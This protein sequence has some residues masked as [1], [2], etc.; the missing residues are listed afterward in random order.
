MA[1]VQAYTQ[2]Q[3]AQILGRNQGPEFFYAQ[4]VTALSSPILSKNLNL[5]RPLER[6]HL[7]LMM[8]V[9]I[10]GADYTT[11]SAEAP[12]NF[13][14]RLV[15]NGTHQTFGA[16]TPINMTGASI[17]TYLRNFRHYASSCYINGV[18]QPDPGVPYQ[19]VGTTFGNIGTYDLEIHYDLPVGPITAHAVKNSMIPYMWQ[20]ADWSD[21][22]QIQPFFGDPTSFG[23]PAGGTTVDLYAYGQNSGTPTMYFFNNYEILGPLANQIAG[24]V[25]I[26]S[27]QTV[28]GPVS[29]TSSIRYSLLFCKSKKR[30]TYLS[31]REHYLPVLPSA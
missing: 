15:V 9:V 3:L 18:R 20:P 29:S 14:Q 31:N 27:A 10:S 28:T 11:V 5:T 24:A 1:G 21:T 16:L 26:R 6:F 7:I 22:I 2:Q 12:W 4:Q 19:Q 17:F 8:R 13:L 30:R 25:V 23:T